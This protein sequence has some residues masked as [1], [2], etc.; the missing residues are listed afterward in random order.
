MTAKIKGFCRN[1]FR[2]VEWNLP[3]NDQGRAEAEQRV[4]MRKT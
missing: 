3:R 4:A 1:L 2:D